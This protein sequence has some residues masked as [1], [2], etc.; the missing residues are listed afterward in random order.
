MRV[1]L[2]IDGVLANFHD[3]FQ[4]LLDKVAGRG[5][6]GRFGE[7]SAP[8]W[9]WHKKIYSKDQI[10]AAWKIINNSTF[11][12]D[13]DQYENMA[14]LI[15]VWGSIPKRHDIYFITARP[16]SEAKYQSEE[17]LRTRLGNSR[18]VTV[19]ISNDKAA[20]AT[21]LDLDAFVDDK[22]ETVNSIYE[23]RNM[24]NPWEVL[25]SP[26]TRVFLQLRRYNRDE[27]EIY[28]G[29]ERIGNIGPIL[30]LVK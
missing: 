4:A 11:Y 5:E 23:V 9:N 28:A 25:P 27:K 29:V 18:Q 13:L 15:D 6:S 2:D 3:S 8:E 10:N 22:V 17:W 26:S 1:G 20:A 14:R 24:K 30:S 12:R 19:L 21:A 7:E 16:Q